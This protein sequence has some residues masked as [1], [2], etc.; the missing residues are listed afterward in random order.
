MNLMSKW[1]K[2]KDKL[3]E[4]YTYVLTLSM[5]SNGNYAT[6]LGI[7]TGEDGWEIDWSDDVGG[8]EDI[9]HWMPLP[10]PPKYMPCI[11]ESCKETARAYNKYCIAHADV[12]QKRGW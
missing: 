10:R 9:T 8:Y 1:R 6:G 7:Y 4:E 11:M 3:P 12:P 5:Y 2:V